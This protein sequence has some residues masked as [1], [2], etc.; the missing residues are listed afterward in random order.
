MLQLLLSTQ[1]TRAR[2]HILNGAEGQVVVQVELGKAVGELMR[3]GTQMAVCVHFVAEYVRVLRLVKNDAAR[4][5]RRDGVQLQFERGR[6]EL[7]GEVLEVGNRGVRQELEQVVVESLGACPVHDHVRDGEH[8]EQQA[9]TL[10]LVAGRAEQTLS[11]EDERVC[12]RVVG[13]PHAHRA[14]FLFGRGGEYVTAVEESV[15]ERVRFSVA[16]VAKDGHAFDELVVTV[17][18]VV[19]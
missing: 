18:V 10:V 7:L 4:S 16:R 9:E 6:L 3:Y 5:E 15:V 1:Q 11:V 13:A 14:R 8:F 19:G 12:M 2:T 17:V